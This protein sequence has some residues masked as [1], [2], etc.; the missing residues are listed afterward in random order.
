MT[1][2]GMDWLNDIESDAV[3]HAE[4][5]ALE[6]ESV[7]TSARLALYNVVRNAFQERAQGGLT[8][9]ELAK[10]I[11]ASRAFVSRLLA[12]PSNMTIE[13]AARLMY[14]MGTELQIAE[15]KAQQQNLYQML[16][17][18]TASIAREPISHAA[19]LGGQPCVVTTRTLGGLNVL[20]V[21]GTARDDGLY[22]KMEAAN[23]ALFARPDAKATSS[24]ASIVLKAKEAAR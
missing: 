17:A 8:R 15:R 19:V 16:F 10:R 12:K 24:S 22:E 6:L 20:S 13:T 5:K 11:D 9:A 18:Q 14:G 1:S 2:D 3:P 23:W 4:L 21:D 7:G